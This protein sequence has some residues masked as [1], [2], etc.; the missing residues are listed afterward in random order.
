MC[1]LLSDPASHKVGCTKQQSIIKWE[2][3]IHDQAR[4]GPEGT[5]K[6]HEEV[7]QMPMVSTPVTIPSA[8]KHVP[9]TSWGIP[10]DRLNEEEKTKAWFTNGSACYAGTIQKWTATALQP[11][12]DNPERHR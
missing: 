10:Y 3:Y 12:R 1:R 11:F 6:L 7:P 9:I 4:A 2:W 5:S 8:A